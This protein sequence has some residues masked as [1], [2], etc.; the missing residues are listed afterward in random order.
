MTFKE[1]QDYFNDLS[2][3]NK[4]THHDPPE[5]RTFFRMDNEEDL[6]SVPD[7]AGSPYIKVL[8]LSGRMQSN[9]DRMETRE[10]IRIRIASKADTTK[11]LSNEIER[12]QEEAYVVMMQFLSKMR[13]DMEE[14]PCQA[15]KLMDIA[16]VNWDPVGPVNQYEYGWNLSIPIKSGLLTYEENDWQ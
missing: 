7:S 11:A 1:I 9:I 5:R 10:T 16:A 8:T 14:K 12:A 6:A 3:N 13:Y 15:L 2:V 4:L